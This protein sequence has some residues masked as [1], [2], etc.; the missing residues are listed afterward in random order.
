MGFA[1]GL[2]MRISL[3]LR[4]SVWLEEVHAVLVGVTNVKAHASIN[5]AKA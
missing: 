1:V 5:S 3:V 4:G 2:K